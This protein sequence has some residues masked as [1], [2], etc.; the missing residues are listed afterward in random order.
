VS[1]IQWG[2]QISGPFAYPG[3]YVDVL[4][5]LDLGSPPATH[6][7]LLFNEGNNFSQANVAYYAEVTYGAGIASG[8]F[9]CDWTGQF[10][11]VCSR[12]TVR[13]LAYQCRA[14][15]DVYIGPDEPWKHG[16]MLGYGG[17]HSKRPLTFTGAERE[18]KGTYVPVADGVSMVRVPRFARRWWPRLGLRV[19][20]PDAPGDPAGVV[21]PYLLAGLTVE[22]GGPNQSIFSAGPSTSNAAYPV[23]MEMIR[24][25]LDV[26]GVGTVSL[27]T[28]SQAV[29]GQAFLY[30]PVFE[31]SI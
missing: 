22:L 27:R 10:A 28:I 17:W 16:V 14:G 18:L 2:N 15:G 12:L 3:T 30:T 20:A 5:N 29:G 26:T 4:S 7:V 1:D 9:L 25:G 11:L 6:G 23:T 21:A 31:L 19:S 24:D 13:A 8:S